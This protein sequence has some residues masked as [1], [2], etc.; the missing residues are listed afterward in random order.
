MRLKTCPDCNWVRQ[1]HPSKMTKIRIFYLG[2]CINGSINGL[3]CDARVNFFR[4]PKI[5]RSELQFDGKTLSLRA[6]C[7]PDGW[8]QKGL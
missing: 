5:L 7:L 4:C 2:E 6:L 3:S 1:N 8:F